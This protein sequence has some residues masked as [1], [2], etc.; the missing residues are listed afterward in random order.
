MEV[1]CILS[2]F[3]NEVLIELNAESWTCESS[4]GTVLDLKYF[5]VLHVGEE[6]GTLV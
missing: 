6:I 1:F 2:S 3:T 5:G 4:D